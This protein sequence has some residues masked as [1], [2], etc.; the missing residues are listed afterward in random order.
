MKIVQV[1]Y[2]TTAGYAAQNQANIKQ[3]MA[4]LQKMDHGGINYNA[5]VQAD[6]KTFVHRAFLR[7]EED[8]KTLNT[9]PSFISFQQQLKA[10][11]PEVP[12]KVELLT[13]V[14]SSSA[15]FNH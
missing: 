3:V 9:L 13:L 11:G 10:S 2:T 8:D 14:E 12:P 1:T 7:S 6:G 5:C 15:I 4:D